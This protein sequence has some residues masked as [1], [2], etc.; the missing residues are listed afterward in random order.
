MRP[1]HS[2]RHLFSVG[3]GAALIEFRGR[4]VVDS[5]DMAAGLGGS[6]QDQGTLVVAIVQHCGDHSVHS[7]HSDVSGILVENCYGLGGMVL[8]QPQ[9]GREVGHA[10]DRTL[11]IR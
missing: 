9:S 5:P 10:C 7:D 8:F 3:F 1:W 2:L 6:A 4:R 11:V